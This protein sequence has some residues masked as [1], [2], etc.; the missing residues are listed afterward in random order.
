MYF[1]LATKVTK[2]LYSCTILV[3]SIYF[4]LKFLVSRTLCHKWVLNR[5]KN[6]SKY[7]KKL[8]ERVIKDLPKPK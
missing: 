4:K 6:I 3:L 7:P 5:Y 8:H 2:K 1:F